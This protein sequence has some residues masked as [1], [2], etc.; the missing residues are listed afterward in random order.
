VHGS[1]GWVAA[2]SLATAG[3]ACWCFRT[4]P[5]CQAWLE[6]W[7]HGRFRFALVR[8][9]HAG[10]SHLPSTPELAP[11][12][13]YSDGRYIGYLRKSLEF[14]ACGVSH[15]AAPGVDVTVTRMARREA[16]QLWAQC[17]FAGG[18]VAAAWAS[19]RRQLTS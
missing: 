12:L 5:R 15:A 8:P 4:T 18:A 1:L 6:L 16:V 11:W 10:Q 17:L 2:I 19:L 7:S 3:V 13:V 14:V 9:D